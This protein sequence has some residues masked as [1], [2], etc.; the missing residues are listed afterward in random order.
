MKMEYSTSMRIF[1]EG[2]RGCYKPL[3]LAIRVA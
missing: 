3:M 1:M 2:I